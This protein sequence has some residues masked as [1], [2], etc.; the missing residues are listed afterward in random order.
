MLSWPSFCLPF[1]RAQ[2]WTKYVFWAYDILSCKITVI[3][4]RLTYLIRPSVL[5]IP[6]AFCRAQAFLALEYCLLECFFNA[7]YCCDQG[8]PDIVCYIKVVLP[9]FAGFKYTF[10]S[11]LLVYYKTLLYS[12]V[13]G[14]SELFLHIIQ[15][16]NVCNTSRMVPYGS[17]TFQVS[18]LGHSCSTCITVQNQMSFC[19]M[20]VRQHSW[21][22]ENVQSWLTALS[23]RLHRTSFC[24]KPLPHSLCLRIALNHLTCHC[25]F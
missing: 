22:A 17:T 24:T 5:G 14:H 20:D 21:V 23:C 13:K 1:Q 4:L 7:I 18:L 11:I 19:I 25:Q 6:I 16:K 9:L 10:R 12:T 8:G 3:T 2:I 15:W